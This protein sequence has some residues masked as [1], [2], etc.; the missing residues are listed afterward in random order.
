MPT[1]RS[2]GRAARCRSGR[3]VELPGRGTTFVREVPGPPGAPTVLLLHGWLASG[4]LNWFQAFERPRR[5]ATGCSPST[6]AAT[7]GASGPAAASASPTAPTTSP[8]SSTQLDAG[9]VDRRRLLPRRARGPAAVAPPPGP[10]RRA[11]CSCATSHHLMPGMREQMLFTHVHGG[12]RRLHPARPA[13]DA[14]CRPAGA[15]DGGCRP[16]RGVAPG[17]DAGLGPGRDAPPRLPPHPRGR[18]GD[19]EL[20]RQWIDE[21]DVPTAVARHHQGPGR[22]PASPSSAWRSRSPGATIHRIDDGHVV[23]AKP[24]FGPALADAVDAVA[25]PP[26][27]CE[28]GHRAAAGLPRSSS[29]PGI[30]PGA[31]L[32]PGA[33]PTSAPTSCGSTGLAPSRRRDPAGAN[34]NVLDRGR[35][36]VGVDLKRP[37]R[38]RAGARAGRRAPTRS[39]EGFRPG[40][41]ER[42]GLGPDDVPRRNPRSSTAA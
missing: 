5:A 3:R 33:R 31:V 29:W 14:R 20:P 2:V 41:A 11:S 38:R 9:P 18:R 27:A 21:I 4:G 1:P 25:A 10:R 34:G 35:R 19:V 12:R 32:R 42:L 40:V 24:S 37:G 30:G 7:A 15:A 17:D 28:H 13:G 22:Q 6:T 23:C 36:S 16:A 39:I 8:P 26:A